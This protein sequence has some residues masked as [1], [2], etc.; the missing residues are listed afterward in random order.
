MFTF[1]N[2]SKVFLLIVLLLVDNVVHV[3]HG[4]TT[5]RPNKPPA[6]K[7][8]ALNID[9][10]SMW[11]NGNAFGKG[12]FRFY[13]SQNDWMKPFPDEDKELYPQLFTLPKGVYEISSVKP[14]G[15]V[16]EEIEP[17]K[18]VYVSDIVEGGNADVQGVVQKGDI[19]IGVTAIKVIGAKWERRLIPARDLSFDVVVNAIMSNEPKW[20]CEDVVLQFERP[21][22]IEDEQAVKDHLAFYN[23]PGDS[24]W[25]TN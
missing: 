3:V 12:Q 23:P 19:L 7:L 22:E 13:K 15:I 18:G 17:G 11:N 8:F 16:F 6:T 14:L 21:S 4:F 1:T 2:N 20:G 9:T 24:A 10:R 25:R 5:S